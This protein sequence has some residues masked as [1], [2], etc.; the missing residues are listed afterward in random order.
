MRASAILAIAASTLVASAPTTENLSEVKGQF[1]ISK[2]V[3]GCTAGCSYSF[4][5][6]ID[7]NLKNHPE[8]KTAVKCEGNFN[9]VTDYKQCG[10]VSDTQK[11]LA[12]IEKSTNKLKLQYVVENHADKSTY[13]YYGEKTVYAATGSNAAL[14]PESFKVDES[15]STGIA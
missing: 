3:F 9:D 8:V 11:I 10:S 15:S 14:Q 4:D 7:G 13:K 5:V 2:F 6:M 1:S 12:F